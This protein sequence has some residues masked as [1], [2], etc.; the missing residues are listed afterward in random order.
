ME[1]NAQGCGLVHRRSKLRQVIER[2]D[3]NFLTHQLRFVGKHK[4]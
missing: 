4:T 1:E 3:L 2:L